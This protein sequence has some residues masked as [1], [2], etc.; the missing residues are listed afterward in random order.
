MKGAGQDYLPLHPEETSRGWNDRLE[1]NVLFNYYEI[2]LDQLAGKPFAEPVSLGT[3]IPQEL[4]DH[5][6]DIDL[7]GNNIDA[8][9]YEWFRDGLRGAVS[10]VLVEFPN[11]DEEVVDPDTGEIRDRTRLDDIREGLR[12][13][14]VQ[15]PLERILYAR[16]ERVNGV[17]TISHVR[18]EEEA[19]ITNGFIDDTVPQIRVLEPGLV[20]LWQKED[21]NKSN[22]RWV[23]VDEWETGLDFVPMVPF[24][25]DREAPFMGRPLLD[26]LAFLNIRHW[27]SMSDQIRALTVAR[28]PM[29]VIKGLYENE[30]GLIRVGPEQAIALPEGGDARWLES[31]GSAIQQGRDELS[32]LEERMSAYGAQVLRKRPAVQT[33]TARVLDTTEAMSVIQ[34]AA[35]SFQSAMEQALLYHAIWLGLDNGGT[36]KVRTDFSGVED[37]SQQVLI[38]LKEAQATRIISTEAYVGELKR[39][40]VLSEDYNLEADRAIIEGE[41]TLDLERMRALGEL[42]PEGGEDAPTETE[43]GDE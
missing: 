21:N 38:S 32:D 24:Y 23:V 17:E 1:N 20:Q 40:N 18:I 2:T 13:Y 43:E 31:T 33:A 14:W 3:D 15:V 4:L 5:L 22:S 35:V 8:F 34:A 7:Q 36:L 37:S 16:T 10:C 25:T 26:D 29:L 19:T 27:Q 41:I 28:F 42:D 30:Q 39:R 6:E 12:P 11:P 9:G